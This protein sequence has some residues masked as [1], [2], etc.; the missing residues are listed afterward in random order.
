MIGGGIYVSVSR[1]SILA[2]VL[3]LGDGKCVY[4][5]SCLGEMSTYSI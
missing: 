3:A 4:T 2:L 1:I 5:K